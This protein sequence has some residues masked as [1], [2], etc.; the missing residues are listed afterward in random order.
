[1]TEAQFPYLTRFL[2]AN[3]YPPRI[4]CGQAFAGKRHGR[5]LGLGDKMRYTHAR[6]ADFQNHSGF[7]NRM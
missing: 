3:R 1:V 6:L 2:L 4:K 7:A 5:W